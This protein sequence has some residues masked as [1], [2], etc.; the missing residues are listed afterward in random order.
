VLVKV[1]TF[2]PSYTRCAGIISVS[3]K[4]FELNFAVKFIWKVVFRD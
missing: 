1:A 2:D 3:N 4:G